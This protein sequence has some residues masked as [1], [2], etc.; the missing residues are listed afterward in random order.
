MVDIIDAARGKW[1][2]ILM[3]LGVASNF[4]KNSHGP[5][6]LCGGK[7]R[8]RW[9][10]QEGSGSYICSNC[11]SGY[12]MC[13]VRNFLNIDYRSAVR[14]IEKILDV[15]K[16]DSKSHATSKLDPE[17]VRRG[18]REMYG[19]TKQVQKGDLVD[20]YFNSR[21]L[22]EPSYPKSLRFANRL[23][24]GQG[25]SR[26]CLVATVV[27]VEGK[28]VTLHRTFLNPNGS[29]KAE[30]ESPRKLAAGAFPA[31]ACVRLSDGDS[32]DTL[33]IAE[34]IETAM[35]A[36]QIYDMP[37]W[38]ALTAGGLEKWEPP[39]G[40][41][42]ISIFGDNDRSF[43]GHNAAYSLAKKLIRKGY[44]VTVH[45]PKQ[46]G[47]DWNDHLLKFKGAA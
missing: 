34:G 28:P 10:N 21:G 30:M 6:P 25:G 7:D 1:R 11:G 24:D 27:D 13:L 15:V 19:Q 17:K 4:L 37:V 5:C 47:D 2:G 39:A 8:W 42:I 46:I 45:F 20:A 43:T 35:S 31:G 38:A 14:E 23:N 40:C 36:S 29:S 12:G 26:P 16:V 33:G 9:D 3:E 41:S 18:L 22:G 44:D 32:E